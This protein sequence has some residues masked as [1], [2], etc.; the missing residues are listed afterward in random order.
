MQSF[1]THVHIEVFHCFSECNHILKFSETFFIDPVY[2]KLISLHTQA[3]N[4][5]LFLAKVEAA[6]LTDSYIPHSLTY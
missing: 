5:N 6:V 1:G 2:I 3:G 4:E